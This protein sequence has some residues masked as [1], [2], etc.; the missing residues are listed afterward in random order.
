MNLENLDRYS[1]ILASNSPR[2]KTLLEGL[3]IPFSIKV[4][5]GVDESFPDNLDPH[6]VPLH[7]A[8]SKARAY[9]PL[10]NND[11]L[12]TADTIVLINDTILGKPADRNDAISMLQ[13]LSGQKHKVITGVCLMSTRK[14]VGFSVIS[15]VH[16]ARLSMSEIEYYVDNYEPFDKAGAYGIQEWIG[17]VGV[18]SIEGS[19]YNVMG[20]PVQRLYRELARF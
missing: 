2:R 11:L 1:I 3:D 5:D 4:V 18:E 9:L 10:G 12:I 20:L 8:R 6:Q 16:F 7:I 14:E 13:T 17:Y 19:F 15:T